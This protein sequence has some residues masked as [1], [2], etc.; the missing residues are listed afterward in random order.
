MVF[1]KFVCVVGRKK[2]KILQSENPFTC[3]FKE[4]LGFV[5]VKPAFPDTGF[6]G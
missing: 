6:S 5:I 4:L 3:Q 1:K 2:D